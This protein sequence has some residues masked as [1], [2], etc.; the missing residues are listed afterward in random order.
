MNTKTPNFEATLAELQDTV[1]ALE[2]GNLPLE[3]ALAQFQRAIKLSKS[4]QKV[5]QEA[6]LKISQIAQDGTEVSP[7]EIDLDPKE[8]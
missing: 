7:P 8:Q 6:E 4:C 1:D 3:D 5:L 2:K